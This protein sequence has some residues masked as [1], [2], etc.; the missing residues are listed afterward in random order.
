MTRPG[1]ISGR[2]LDAEGKPVAGARVFF[3]R[4]PGPLP[5][6]AAVTGDDGAFALSAPHAGTYH[7]QS[8]TDGE[9]A[10]T[11]EVHVDAGEHVTLDIAP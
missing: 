4:G 6:V 7:V 1:V 9:R 5:D 11:V 3:A 2:V 10:R 8:V